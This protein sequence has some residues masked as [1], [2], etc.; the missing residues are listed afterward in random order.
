MIVCERDYA[1]LDN[2]KITKTIHTIIPILLGKLHI[3]FM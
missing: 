3:T 1:N 2:N